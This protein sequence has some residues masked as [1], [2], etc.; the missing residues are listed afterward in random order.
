[1]RW[2]PAFRG[3]IAHPIFATVK[4]ITARIAEGVRA[5]PAD[6]WDACA[7]KGNPFLSHAF[8]SALEDSGSVG[9]GSG[10]QI[11]RAHV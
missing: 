8:L 10:W 4:A 7:G 3:S 2:C 1:M 6:Q 5:V 11:G 9:P